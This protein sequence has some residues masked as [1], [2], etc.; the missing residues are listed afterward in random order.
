MRTFQSGLRSLFAGEAFSKMAGVSSFSCYLLIIGLF[1][2]IYLHRRNSIGGILSESVVTFEIALRAWQI[3]WEAVD[4]VTLDPHSATSPFGLASAALFR[5]SFIR[6]N[7]E[8]EGYCG[9]LWG[10]SAALI[11]EISALDRSLHVER[12]VLHA[13]HAL[14]MLVRLG[15]SFMATTKTSIWS[16]EHSVCSLESAVLLKNWLAT[17]SAVVASSGTS[18][19]RISEKK[20]LGIITAI[21]KETDYADIL[22]LPDENAIR[23]QHLA[24][25]VVAL[26]SSLFQGTHILEIDDDVSSALRLLA[27]STQT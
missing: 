22:S 20:L 2:R 5:L 26:W 11:N 3:S 12:A 15:I 18:G 6:L 24:A 17:I 19:L 13:A 1:Q 7:V 27:D 4:E 23:Y 9:M 25:A 14:S 21:I 10:G 8:H 16:I